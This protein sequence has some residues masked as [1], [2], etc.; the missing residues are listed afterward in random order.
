[1]TIYTE[2]MK[3]LLGGA[4]LEQQQANAMMNKLMSGDVSHPQA[5]ALLTALA[6]KGVTANELAG[7]A[8][9]MR[10]NALPLPGF[11]DALDTCGTGG[12][13]LSTINTST[14]C[15]FIVAA[16]GVKV[17]KHGNR[18]S[19][20]KCGSADV[21][22]RLGV[23][24]SNGPT[25][26]SKLLREVGVSFLFAPTYHPAM[27]HVV[28]VRRALGFRTVFN[29]LGPLCN[30]SRAKRQ[31]I[32]VSDAKMAELMAHALAEMGCDRAMLAHGEDGLDELSLCAPTRL[33]HV[34]HG[35]VR[36]DRITPE[37]LGLDTVAPQAIEGGDVAINAA[38]F[39]AVLSGKEGG[40]ATQH[41]L[42]NAAAGLLVGGVVTDWQQGLE[43][44][45]QLVSSG[46]AWRT[47][48]AFRDASN[49]MSRAA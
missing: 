24:L 8:T 41:V 36:Q 3:R 2:V 15:A 29:F 1:M 5:A 32:G 6:I 22:E 12:S 34:V 47:F 21:L 31:M 38:I 10:D 49:D 23:R 37:D 25:A 43:T 7:F 20:G 39:E 35:Q 30:P 26:A 48:C 44:S 28:P 18:S 40:P 9:A 4:D 13:G 42:L 27:R 46:A 16:A 11:Q 45:R 19:S 17:A 33:W 14:M